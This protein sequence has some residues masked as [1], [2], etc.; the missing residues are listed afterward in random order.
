LQSFSYLLRETVIIENQI[1]I[2]FFLSYQ[3]NENSAGTDQIDSP[4]PYKV[5]CYPFNLRFL[6]HHMIDGFMNGGLEL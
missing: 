3:V 4:F 6:P 1:R 5:P 2:S